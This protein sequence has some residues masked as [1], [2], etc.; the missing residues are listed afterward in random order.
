MDLVFHALAD[1]SR[2][3]VMRCISEGGEVSVTEI[4]SQLPISRQAVSKHLAALSD[5]GL[6]AFE[7]QGR[8]KLYRLTPQPLGDALAW[9]AEV[10][11]DWD[12]RLKSLERHLYR[13]SRR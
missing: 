11:A 7:R 10:G 3:Q 1:P 12:T 8:D 13:S 2:R 5:A 9:M 6:V 4:A